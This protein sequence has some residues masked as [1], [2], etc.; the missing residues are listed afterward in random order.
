MTLKNL[1]AEER[2]VIRR[3]LLATFEFFDFDFQTRLGV[4]PETVREIIGKWPAVDDSDDNSDACLA[5]NNALNDLLFG[6]GIKDHKAQEVMGV[7]RAEL[8][9]IYKKWAKSRGWSSTGIR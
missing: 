9:R 6:V 7:Y 8:D 1:T 3:A 5:I 2:D 4:Y